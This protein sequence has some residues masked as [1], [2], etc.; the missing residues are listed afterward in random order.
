MNASILRSMLVA[1]AGL[2]GCAVLGIL[3]FLGT[4]VATPGSQFNSE[5]LV[6]SF[7]EGIEIK[8]NRDLHGDGGNHKVKIKVKGESDVYV[9]RNRVPPG[10]HSGWHSH[11]GPS[12][13]SVKAGTATV[14]SGDDPY[15]IPVT[16]PAGT[17]FIDQGGDHV[18]MVRNEGTVE[19]EVI[20]FQIVPAGA[21]RRIDA[22]SPGYC[23][24]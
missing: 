21:D 12:I 1:L 23:P 6:R 24:F 17:G 8:T 13:V 18:H 22:P 19:L 15:C 10:G 11:P 5:I 9:V 16:Y 14:Y 2:I 4:A 3:G 7:F 20:A